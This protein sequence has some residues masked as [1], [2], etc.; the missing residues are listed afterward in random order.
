MAMM[1]SPKTRLMPT[2]RA[3][4]GCVRDDGGRPVVLLLGDGGHVTLR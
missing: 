2:E 4:A 3:V 1:I